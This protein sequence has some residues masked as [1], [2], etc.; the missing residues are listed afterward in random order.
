MQPTSQMSFN[1]DWGDFPNKQFA[2]NLP[3]GKFE[4][5]SEPVQ[6]Y[7]ACE[8]PTS[9][10]RLEFATVYKIEE[11]CYNY[12]QLHQKNRKKFRKGGCIM[13]NDRINLLGNRQPYFASIAQ[14]GYPFPELL[15]D[16]K[17]HHQGQK[18][19]FCP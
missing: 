15:I 10:K 2:K 16:H 6:V 8:F 4:K 9:Q 3:T 11:I 12:G 1:G 13:R 19:I 5:M 18:F 7:T 14:H 17:N